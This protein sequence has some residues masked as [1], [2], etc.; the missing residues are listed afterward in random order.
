MIGYVWL[1][2][3]KDGQRDN[4]LYFRKKDLRSVGRV[5]RLILGIGLCKGLCGWIVRQWVE[6]LQNRVLMGSCWKIGM[7]E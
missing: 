5:F 7:L 3:K 2:F 1:V 6:G 4:G